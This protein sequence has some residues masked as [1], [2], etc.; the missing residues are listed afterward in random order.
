MRIVC[1]NMQ[2]KRA[3]WH[4]LSEHHGDADLALLHLHPPAEVTAKLDVGPGPWVNEGWNGA[5]AVVRMSDR[6]S[7]KRVS[8]ADVI[9]SAPPNPPLTL[10][11]DSR[12]LSPR[13]LAVRESPSSPSNQPAVRPRECRR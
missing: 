3:S 5:R 7:I 1:W 9:A 13:C 8:V 4:F 11:S 10:R 6:I 2:H 12:S